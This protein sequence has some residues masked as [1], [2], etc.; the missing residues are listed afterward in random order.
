MSQARVT[1]F[2]A[3]TKKVSV[4]GASRAKGLKTTQGVV[5]N[6]VSELTTDIV[7]TRPSSRSTRSKNR[8]A[9][10]SITKTSRSSTHSETSVQQEFLRVID[11]AASVDKADRV[12]DGTGRPDSEKQSILSSPR[13]PKRTSVD[14]EF[15]LGSAVFS[16]TAE[17]STAKKRLR[18]ESAKD[19]SSEKCPEVKTVKKTARKKL[20]LSKAS[21]QVIFTSLAVRLS[22]F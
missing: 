3:Q 18:A 21:E 1:D 14:A 12:Y 17:H 6:G 8:N 16:T 5:D 2:F 4:D 13:T 15:D 7:A 11:E 9:T 19:N 20:I 22:T 10:L